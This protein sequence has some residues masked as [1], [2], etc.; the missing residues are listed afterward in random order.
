MKA[1]L[2]VL[3]LIVSAVG[4]SF[5]INNEIILEN[6]M[7]GKHEN[8]I[9]NFSFQNNLKLLSTSQDNKLKI[10]SLHEQELL[11][12]INFENSLKKA[13]FSTN[14]SYIFVLTSAKFIV[15]DANTYQEISHIE[16]ES[17]RDFC[18]LEDT[19]EVL[20]IN[21]RQIMYY[22]L[23]KRERTSEIA[24]EGLY[25]SHTLQNIDV[26]LNKKYFVVS[27]REKIKIYNLQ[28]KSLLNEIKSLQGNILAIKF[29]D[30]NHIAIIEPNYASIYD[31]KTSSLIYS[32]KDYS[33]NALQNFY[34]KDD[35][36][37]PLLV[38]EENQNLK[39]VDMKQKENIKQAQL[40]KGNF[41]NTTI[42]I[43][44]DNQLLAVGNNIGDIWIYKLKDFIN[45]SKK[46]TGGE[47]VIGKNIQKQPIAILPNKAP[48]L[49]LEASTIEGY[50]PLK[51][52]FSII[53]SDDKKID[54]Y[55]INI[56]GNENVSKGVPPT[57]FSKTFYNAGEFKIVVVVKDEEG[58]ITQKNLIVKVKEK[59]FLDYKKV[60]D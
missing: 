27:D 47:P 21:G 49:I 12:E 45:T 54:S 37:Q 7:K 60:F 44:Q 53:A 5:S 24:I 4:D 11:K 23:G 38:N 41:L 36:F 55:Y 16:G 51:V 46:M 42:E 43:S 33:Q 8:E 28:K 32:S 40:P 22:T 17:L 50:N 6:V 58:L 18:V 30:D 26:S 35:M 2:I 20:L 15:L 31:F 10:W 14:G 3:I 9:I 25:A 29:I 19:N 57:S 52:D 59:T 56:A 48:D 34:M 13:I 39:I 1:F